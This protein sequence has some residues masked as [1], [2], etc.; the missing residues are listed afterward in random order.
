[1]GC[2]EDTSRGGYLPI[3][4]LDP[5]GLLPPGLH[6]C[7]T[8]EILDRFGSFQ[9]SDRRPRLF[10]NLQQYIS[11]LKTAEIG[12]YLVVDGSFVTG[13]DSPNDIDVLLVLKDDFDPGVPLPP[14]KYNARSR[15]YIRQHFGLDFHF[16][17]EGH[18]SATE[19]LELFR[20]VKYRPGTS[21]GL[22]V[23]RL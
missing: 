11:E 2:G 15:R 8:D 10:R 3:P 5:S 19:I 18:P 9:G 14:F 22:L 16:G 23:V 13:T 12:K 20:G 1:M 7:T 17:F 4:D 6:E 21:K